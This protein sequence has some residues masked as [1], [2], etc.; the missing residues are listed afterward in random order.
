MSARGTCAVLGGRGFVGS[1]VVRE[2]QERGWE[3]TVIGREEYAAHRGRDFDLFVNADGNSRKYLAEQDPVREFE[4]SVLSVMRSLVDFRFDRYVLLSSIDVYPDCTD[5]RRNSED[6]AIEPQKLS[7]YGFHKY[8]AELIVQRYARD[9]MILRMGGFVG[10]GLWKNSIYDLLRG[11]PLRVHPESR[12][13]YLHTR[14]LARI[15]FTLL[16]R[17]P[18]EQRIF[19]VAGKGTISLR[20]VA[21]LIPGCTPRTIGPDVPHEVYEVSIE[22]VEQFHPVPATRE[23]VAAFVRAV[24]D[25]KETIR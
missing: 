11:H 5:P 20:E 19:N 1:A 3:V 6:T 9:W 8:L 13:Q 18:R 2:A 16:E 21:E 15:L 4:M 14:D 24:L 7:P 12:Y 23:T 17:A 25:G 10:P 22:R